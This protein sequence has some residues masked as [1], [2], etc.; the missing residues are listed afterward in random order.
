MSAAEPE[1]EQPWTEACHQTVVTTTIL[2]WNKHRVQA[3]KRVGDEVDAIISEF[4][5]KGMTPDQVDRDYG[6]GF[7]C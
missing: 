4:D 3:D 1:K 7:G 2:R 6:G 5:A